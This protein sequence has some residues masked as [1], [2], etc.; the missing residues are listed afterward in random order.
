MQKIQWLP[1]E[2]AQLAYLLRRR[3]RIT[4]QKPGTLRYLRVMPW[5]QLRH[6]YPY[7]QCGEL[8]A[9]FSGHHG[10]GSTDA[11]RFCFQNQQAYPE[12]RKYEIYRVMIISSSIFYCYF[13]AT[14][15]DGNC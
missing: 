12:P 5:A 15:Y 2:V 4:H 11:V 14:I 3:T 8:L 10:H 7:E 1:Y 9:S 13:H 6:I